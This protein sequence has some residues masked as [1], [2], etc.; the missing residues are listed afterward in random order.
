M[1]NNTALSLARRIVRIV[2]DNK[3]NLLQEIKDHLLKKAPGK[4]NGFLV[5]K[6]ILTKESQK[7]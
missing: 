5:H 4:S 1:K 3:N 7:Q 2:T 6:I